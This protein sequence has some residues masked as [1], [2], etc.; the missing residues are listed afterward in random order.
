MVAGSQHYGK[1]QPERK[2]LTD[3]QGIKEF[4]IRSEYPDLNKVLTDS[5]L[6]DEAYLDD[7]LKKYI[8]P[9][10]DKV[11]QILGYD[12]D[13]D[14][15][16][17]FIGVAKGY[18]RIMEKSIGECYKNESIDVYTAMRQTSDMVRG[19]IIYT[20]I[21]KLKSD[22]DKIVK[23]GVK[24]D[25]PA[26]RLKNKLDTGLSNIQIDFVVDGLSTEI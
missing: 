20:D 10:T 13:P 17:Y 6:S 12:A 18:P 25:F 15:P 11:K 2:H 26:I 21:E 7:F 8:Q 22:V 19:M 14:N 3:D 9:Y 5:V 23:E 1:E 24:Q 4:D 16:P